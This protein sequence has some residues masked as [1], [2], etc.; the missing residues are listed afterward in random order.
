MCKSCW[1]RSRLQHAN[2]PLPADYVPTAAFT[3]PTAVFSEVSSEKAP[4]ETNE[5]VPDDSGKIVYQ[6]F[7]PDLYY[8]SECRPVREIYKLWFRNQKFHH[9]RNFGDWLEARDRCRKDLFYLGQW[10]LEHNFKEH[11]H[12]E[13]CEMF[14][15]KNFD[16]VYHD[17]YTLEEVRNNGIG[18]QKRE[19]EMLLLC[20]RGAFKST[21]NKVDCVQWLL[22]APDIRILIVTGEFKLAMKFLKET[23]GYFYKPE[24]SDPTLLQALFPEYVIDEMPGATTSDFFCPARICPQE[25][26]PSL[27]CNSITANL[28]GWHCDV[29]KGDDVV[30]DE[31][32]NTEDARE[33]LKDKYDNA[34]N[35]T[36]SWGFEDH[37]GT[38]YFRFDWYG[39]R[40]DNAKADPEHARLKYLVRAAWTVKA[41]YESV[42]L[43]SLE[44]HMVDLYFPEV[45]TWALLKGK[46]RNNEKQFRCQQMNDP[47]GGLTVHFG[48]DDM[49]A[50]FLP[51]A[52][53][54]Q[55][56]NVYIAW[57]TA[58]STTNQ[59]DFSAAAVMRIGSNNEMVVLEVLFD[60]WKPSELAYQFVAL[61]KKWN[62]T[63]TLAEE[64]S[65]SELFK[66]ELGRKAAQFGVNLN[67]LIW[68]KPSNSADAKR[69]RIKGLEILLDSDRLYFVNGVWIDELMLQF[70]KYTGERKSRK[71]DDIPDAIAYLQCFMPLPVIDD[72]EF[73]AFQ[74]QE[75]ERQA[76][77]QEAARIFCAP[78]FQT[79]PLPSEDE[80]D[81]NVI[82]LNPMLDA[83]G[84]L[85]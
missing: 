71:H 81:A 13:M 44:K 55:T 41:G 3:R 36:D 49:R 10:V 34:S 47:A 21:V 29:K 76:S 5:P 9:Y 22:N 50:H 38:R 16:G 66:M 77:L 18:K 74:K 30:T 42:P 72:A 20:P 65:G 15:Q 61:Q 78:T 1:K 12:R 56:G 23:L 27:W 73:K 6:N 32:S 60:R 46:C 33:K 26:Q 35:L 19:R 80:S 2:D 82:N 59:A 83:R 14:V 8:K 28:S 51:M 11:V 69:N 4:P 75:A 53:A 24:K 62:P 39:V 25:G 79:F 57:D 63:A 85:F 84:R 68:R 58:F 67:N 64:F 54:P 70:T 37:I 7:A 40:I 48:E 52:A 31:N 17:G 45:L 43:K